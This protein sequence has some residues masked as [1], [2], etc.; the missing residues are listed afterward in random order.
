[1]RTRAGLSGG[2]WRGLVVV[3][4]VVG[5]L[6]APSMAGAAAGGGGWW[7]VLSVGRPTLLR[8]GRAGDEVQELVAEPN[9]IFQL[10]VDGKGINPHGGLFESEQMPDGGAAGPVATAAV[11]QEELEDHVYGVGNVAVT[12]GPAG[13]GVA[14]TITSVGEDADQLVAPLEIGAEVGGVVDAK[15]LVEGSADGEIVVTAA[16][17]GDGPVQETG[18]VPV[19]VADVLPAGLRAVSIRAGVPEGFQQILEEIKS[20]SLKEL[21]CTLEKSLPAFEQVKLRI[22]V[23]VEPGAKTGEVNT[24]SVS[25]GGVPSAEAGFPVS[26]G[27]G[28]A[29]F[30]IESFA[31]ANEETGGVP[32]V[33]AG[34]HPDQQTTAIAFN[35]A[36]ANAISA[37]VPA[38]TKDVNVHW[39]P[40]LIGDPVPIARCSL[41]EFFTKSCPQ[42]SI[43]G[44]G[45]TIVDEPGALGLLNIIVPVYNLEPSPG[46]AARFGLA[47][48]ELPVYIDA[49]VRTGEDYGVTVHVENVTQE[50]TFLSSEIT[51]WAVPGESSHDALRGEGCL[52]EARGD[53]AKKVVEEGW[54]PCQALEQANPPAFLTLPSACTGPLPAGGEADSWEAPQAMG[55]QLAFTGPALPALDGCNRLPF[56]PSIRVTADGSAASTPTGLSVDEHVPQE[57]TLNAHG[58]AESDV[59]GLSV[60]LPAGVAINP[61][62]GDGLLS[63]TEAQIGLQS[64]AATACP[65]DA[66]VANVTVRTPVLAN[67][68]KGAAYIAA[69]NE[70]PFGSL[71]AMYIYAEDPVSGVRIKSAGEVLVSQATGQLAAHFEEDPAFKGSPETSRFLP[72]APFEDVEVEFFGGER[73]PLAT[74]AHCGA[75]TTTGTF[76]PWSS[77]Q[78]P[79][80]EAAAMTVESQSTFDIT[81]GPHATPCPGASLPFQPAL[82]GGSTNIN[83]G[84]FTPF[85]TTISREDG[86]QNLGSVTLH[87]PDGLEGL[88]TSVKLC[89]E[90]QANAGT[91]SPESE[92]GETTVSAG[93]GDEPVSVTG[94]RVYIT[95]KYAGAPFGLSIVNPVKAGPFDLEH[96]TANPEYDPPCD[97]I[98]V[99]ARIEIN[100]QTGQL[101]ITTDQTGPHAIPHI[102]DG[103]PVQ[104]KHV[105]VLINRPN[106]T[107]NPTNCSP[108][109]ITGAIESDEGTSD[110]LTTPFQATNCALLKFALKLAVS[111]KAHA[112][113]ANGQSLTF[114]FAYP[115]TPLG[116]QA[117]LNEVKLTIPKQ[118]PVELN[119]I[120]QACLAHTFETDR[121]ACPTHSIIG[122]A[123]VHT[124]VLP[125]PLEGPIY[126]VSYGGQKF[127]EA[128]LVLTGYGITIE[129]HGE[130]YISKG[131]TSATFRNIPD[132]PFETLEVNIPNGPYSEFGANLPNK[133]KNDFC[134]QKLTM[135]TLLKASNGLQTN[136]NTLIQITGCPKPKHHTKPK[137]TKK[138][139]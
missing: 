37:Q 137:H 11:I 102:I 33:Q 97:C 22:G 105:N 104:I 31:M 55:E 121:K 123:I 16:D 72:Q 139:K 76:T 63:C 28:V 115:K 23:V 79:A 69:Q 42:Q 62:A 19:R 20:C 117:W 43:V 17:V 26:V 90:T 49:T 12:G 2:L 96:D 122:H 134:G 27:E 74:P 87:M 108:T 3:V 65:E 36:S 112:S 24:V 91:C 73:A 30:G 116:T 118:L 51:V 111:T 125:V 132:V 13:S 84:A 110:P 8:A 82:T 38:L 138:H 32:D 61:S 18:G 34:S 120:Q 127:P 15:V 92:I 128:V 81:S 6:V 94:G 45:T 47:P 93:V 130:T 75:Y 56:S 25:G 70:N 60:T 10:E 39:P 14:L 136:Q 101:T 64:P 67:P 100:P 68:L 21:A 44:V 95:E 59:K 126:F 109:A 78:A 124:Q 114:K 77:A 80:P 4:V 88:L 50:I 71:M 119:A 5:V 99:R 106:F 46:E 86:Q 133:A 66:K 40:G 54:T 9:T 98:V 113:K 103:I 129:Q 57:S 35:T 89:P 1:M 41:A 58:L 52:K 83:A 131:I 107:F 135:P 85:T 29:P 48:S 53:T 7:R